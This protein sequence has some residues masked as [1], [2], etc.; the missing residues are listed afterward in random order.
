MGERDSLPGSRRSYFFRPVSA[1]SRRLALLDHVMADED[2]TEMAP[3]TGEDAP[4]DTAAVTHVG[5]GIADAV[6]KIPVKLSFVLGA[7][8]MQVN[9]RLKLVRD[10]VME[11]DPGVGEPI[12]IYA[13]NHRIA[14]GEVVVVDYRLGVTIT[15][16]LGGSANRDRNQGDGA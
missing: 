9:W 14:R 12:D 11:L 13:N 7:S 6:A 4:P 1:E 16:V 3:T 5:F 10:A 8:T 2:E 15:E